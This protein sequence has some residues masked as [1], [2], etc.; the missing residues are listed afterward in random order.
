MRSGLEDVG[1]IIPSGYAAY[2]RLFHPVE[3]T[4]GPRRWADVARDNGRVVHPEMQFHM[5][6]R[7]VGTP[8]P[9][10]CERVDGP[11]WG[12][13][14]L[15]ERRMLIEHLMIEALRAE[16]WSRCVRGSCP[17]RR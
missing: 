15:E 3:G 13:L 11:D 4:D 10:G 17:S 14:P 8:A 16:P 1:A 5:V 12:S 2:G 7:P 6:N 9:S